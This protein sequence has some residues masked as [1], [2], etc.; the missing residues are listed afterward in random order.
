LVPAV[1]IELAFSFVVLWVPPIARLLG[2]WNPPLWGWVVA[3]AAV[4]IV[5]GVDALDK[6]RR[7]RRRQRHTR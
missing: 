3:V 2:Q 1:L 5:F 6:Y 7:P 4:P